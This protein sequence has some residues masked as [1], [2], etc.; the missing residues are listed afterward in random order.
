MLITLLRGTA[1]NMVTVP[2]DPQ[3]QGRRSLSPQRLLVD[4]DEGNAAGRGPAWAK[5]RQH[6]NKYL[7]T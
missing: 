1:V 4:K 6:E 5:A 2:P 7:T 3:G